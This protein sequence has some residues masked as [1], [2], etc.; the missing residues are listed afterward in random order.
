DRQMNATAERPETTDD[1]LAGKI[2]PSAT[3]AEWVE[4]FHRDGY[5]F[6]P[7]VLPPDWCAELRQDLDAALDEAGEKSGPVAL[8]KCMFERSAANLRL[9]DVEPIVSF[10]EALIT[11]PCHVIHNNSFKSFT[12]GG[13]ITGWHQDDSSHML[14]THGEP[15]TNI[16]LPV[17]LF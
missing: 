11:G 8:A 5:L 12:E 13:G 2:L 3:I 17:L 6:I 16:R 1:Y 10:A 4:Q 7:N 9:F 14:V 15:P